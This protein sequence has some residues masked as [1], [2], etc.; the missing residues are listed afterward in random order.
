[1]L[2]FIS[3]LITLFTAVHLLWLGGYLPAGLLPT[4]PAQLAAQGLIQHHPWIYVGFL[5]YVFL[6]MAV[7]WRHIARRTLPHGII[8]S[9]IILPT[10]FFS[11][12]VFFYGTEFS[13]IY[14]T[15]VSIVSAQTTLS[16]FMNV[17]HRSAQPPPPEASDR[18]V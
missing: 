1:M 17:R 16:S 3:A 12:Y 15:L 8:R 5:G 4:H 2:V 6:G 9:L 14:W 11:L 13:A 18:Q 10:L 7:L